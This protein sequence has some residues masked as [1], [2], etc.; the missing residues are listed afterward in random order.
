MEFELQIDDHTYLVGEIKERLDELIVENFSVITYIDK[1]DYDITKALEE[2]DVER[3]KE[4]LLDA[5]LE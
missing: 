4:R 5:Y 1:L 2:K 3:F